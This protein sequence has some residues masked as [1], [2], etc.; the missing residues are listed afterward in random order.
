MALFAIA[1]I[2]IIPTLMQAG[3]NMLFAQEAY[4]SHLQAQRTMLVVRDALEDGHN[5]ELMATLYAAGGFDFSFWIFDGSVRYFHSLEEM[6]TEAD[7]SITGINAIMANHATIIIV[8]IWGED[9]QIAGR[10]IGM[11][12]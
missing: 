4:A 12:Y 10:A 8:V 6:E 2:A 11:L 5:P 1:M 3:R 7:V 9:E